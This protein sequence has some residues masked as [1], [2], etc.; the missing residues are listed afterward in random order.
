M[1]RVLM[2]ALAA[3]LLQIGFLSWMIGARASILRNGTEV[4]LKVEPVDPRDLL[5]GD[6]V[7]LGYEIGTIPVSLVADLTPEMTESPGGQV[8]V[9]LAKG[10]DG[11]W[12]VASAFLRTPT[13]S[14]PAGQVDLRGELPAGWSLAPDATLSVSYGIDRYYVPEGRGQAIERD[15]RVRSFGILVAVAEDGTPQ[16]KALL[17]NGQPLFEEPL[18]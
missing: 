18:F 5:R 16:I 12:H 13:S 10:A 17:D 7:W 8:T 15:L 2:A 11:F 9:R 4:V 3:A 14:P 6:Y 1:N